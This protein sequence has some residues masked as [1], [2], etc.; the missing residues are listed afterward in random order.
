MSYNNFFTKDTYRSFYNNLKNEPLVEAIYNFIFCDTSAVSMITST[1][2]GRP[3]LEGILFEVELFLQIAVDYNIVTLLDDN[4][5]SDSLKQCIGTMVKDVL[6]LYGY[7]TEFNPSR[8]L[9]INGGKFI[10]SAS[11]YKKII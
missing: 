5:P 11:S 7:K 3:A 6:E 1:K 9:P 10:M 2:N 8:A 4:V